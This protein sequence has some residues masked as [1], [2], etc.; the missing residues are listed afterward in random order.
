MAGGEI[1][2]TPEQREELEKQFAANRT[3]QA[4]LTSKQRLEAGEITFELVRAPDDPPVYDDTIQSELSAFSKALRAGGVSYSQLAIAMDA[5]DATGYP[6]AEFIIRTLG[7]PAIALVT[8]AV[9]G[10][11]AG[12]GGRKARV[13][14]GD[15]EAEAQTPL[16][17]ED[18]L[19]KAIAVL[20]AHKNTK[21]K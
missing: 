20:E 17:V 21:S 14:I 4:A 19:K 3:L 12:R 2:M 5:V 7:P 1:T 10:W 13:K 16:E 8:G 11:L 15:I 6:L 9:T 18:L